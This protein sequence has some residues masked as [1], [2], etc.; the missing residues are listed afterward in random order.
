MM[1]FFSVKIKTGSQILQAWKK[2][3]EEMEN[4]SK[5]IR[6]NTEHLE[7]LC[8]DRMSQMCQ[9]KRKLKKLFQEEHA[10]I[11]TRFY[12]VNFTVNSDMH[13][14]NYMSLNVLFF[15]CTF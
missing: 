15:H 9:E 5:L 11:A 12:Q 13:E 10:K 6:T 14:E 4:Q 2:F 3:M 1:I 8:T 7:S